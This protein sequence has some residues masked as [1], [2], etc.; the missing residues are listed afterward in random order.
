MTGDD[1]AISRLIERCSSLYKL[2]RLMAWLLQSQTKF[3]RRTKKV[4]L[5]PLD[6]LLSVDEL[7]HAETELIKF[8]QRAHFSGVFAQPK[9]AEQIATKNLSHYLQKLHPVTVDCLL[10]VSGRLGRAP[11][12]FD[13]KH[14]V[15]HRQRS[16]FTELVIRK[17][18]ALVGHSGASHTWASLRQNLWIIKEDVAMRSFIGHCVLCKKRNSSLNKQFIADLPPSVTFYCFFHIHLV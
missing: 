7:R 17:Y 13:S 6:M 3:S 12:D 15:I 4:K 18:Y 1:C 8:L 11:V 16:H 2:K 9:Y 14:P 5:E 10:L